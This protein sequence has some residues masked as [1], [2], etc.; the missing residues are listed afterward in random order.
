MRKKRM[1]ERLKANTC[2]SPCLKE[3]AVSTEMNCLG[4]VTAS[5]NTGVLS[6]EQV[7]MSSDKRKTG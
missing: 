5:Y 2:K 6:R 7:Q 4:L 3:E 1:K